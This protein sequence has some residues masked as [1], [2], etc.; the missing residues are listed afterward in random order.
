MRKHVLEPTVAALRAPAEPGSP[1]AKLLHSLPS[2]GSFTADALR[3]LDL[4]GSGSP[5]FK[6]WQEAAR[7]E[8]RRLEML[9]KWAKWDE[10]EGAGLTT[11]LAY[12]LTC[13]EGSM[14]KELGSDGEAFGCCPPSEAAD[15][16]DVGMV[17][18]PPL[19]RDASVGHAE[20]R[21]LLALAARV[22]EQ[23]PPLG[24]GND[25]VPLEGVVMLHSLRPPSVASIF[26]MQQFLRL[27]P[28]V[29][30][31]VGFGLEGAPPR[32]IQR[33][34]QRRQA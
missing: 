14:A 31:Y 25:A 11:W 5:T 15:D 17:L 18:L 1:Q 20:R 10:C 30:F 16:D 7:L 6:R 32:P 22:F 29:Q 34:G 2:F 24:D 21:A 23:A 26:S 33:I 4:D 13:G 8:L 27:F 9:R 12:D 19:V 28:G 3:M